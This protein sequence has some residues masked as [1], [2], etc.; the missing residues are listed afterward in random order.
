MLL[1]SSWWWKPPQESGAVILTFHLHW[2]NRIFPLSRMREPSFSHFASLLDIDSPPSFTESGLNFVVTEN[3][4]QVVG[5]IWRC[6]L[7]VCISSLCFK[8]LA[9]C[10]SLQ[11]VLYLFFF[12]CTAGQ[13]RKKKEIPRYRAAAA[14]VVSSVSWLFSFPI[15]TIILYHMITWGLAVLLCVEGVAMLYYPSISE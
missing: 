7:F 15:S 1:T 6:F 11:S 2:D 3:I 13:K 8:G 10:F 9:I 4:Y 12:R 5:C 14:C